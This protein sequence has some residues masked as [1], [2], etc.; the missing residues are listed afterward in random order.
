MYVVAGGFVFCFL[1]R[2][3]PVFL[4]QSQAVVDI[5][6]YIRKF[7][8]RQTIIILQKVNHIHN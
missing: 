8:Q 7:L 3:S 6:D 5:D 2:S 4:Q 1:Q